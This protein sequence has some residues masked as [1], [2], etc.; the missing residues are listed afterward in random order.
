MSTDATTRSLGPTRQSTSTPLQTEPQN[1]SKSNNSITNIVQGL[2]IGLTEE[3][4]SCLSF[5]SK[6]PGQ[7]QAVKGEQPQ[8]HKPNNCSIEDKLSA[9]EIFNTEHTSKTDKKNLNYEA[10]EAIISTTKKE[11]DFISD[12]IRVNS[13]Q[14]MSWS[15]NLYQVN[16]L[17]MEFDIPTNIFVFEEDLAVPSYINFHTK[18]AHQLPIVLSAAI[19]KVLK[20]SPFETTNGIHNAKP[21]HILH[22]LFGNRAIGLLPSIL[23][24]DPRKVDETITHQWFAAIKG[25]MQSSTKSDH[26]C[27]LGFHCSVLRAKNLPWPC[28]CAGRVTSNAP[29]PSSNEIK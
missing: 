27:N 8:Q 1:Q 4:L 21:E 10:L 5:Q 24:E 3:T 20:L 2:S 15:V 23:P 14:P 19:D 11:R 29:S 22:T 7:P 26:S 9:K 13:I 17:T 25:G 16:P 18:K 6:P 12:I 28:L